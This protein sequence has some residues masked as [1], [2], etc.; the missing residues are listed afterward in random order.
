ME[1]WRNGGTEEG[2]KEEQEEE[3]EGGNLL[4]WL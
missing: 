4:I 1:E 3:G 2:R